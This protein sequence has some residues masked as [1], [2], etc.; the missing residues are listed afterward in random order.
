MTNLIAFV[1]FS[2]VRSAVFFFMDLV[3]VTQEKSIR[4]TADVFIENPLR[5]RLD[6]VT[7]SMSDNFTNQTVFN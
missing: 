4:Q 7:V 2:H 5:P 1:D 3:T 6:L